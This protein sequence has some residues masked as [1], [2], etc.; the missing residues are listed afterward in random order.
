[1]RRLTFFIVLSIILLGLWRLNRPVHSTQEV[2]PDALASPNEELIKDHPDLMPAQ[3]AVLMLSQSQQAFAA[4]RVLQ[5]A[6]LPAK[7]MYI[8][9]T[10]SYVHA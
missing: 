5:A 9:N 1:M 7:R 2:P 8:Y 6:G 4:A 3:V 10:Y